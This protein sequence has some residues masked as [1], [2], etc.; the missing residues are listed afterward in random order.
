MEYCEKARVFR[1]MHDTTTIPWTRVVVRTLIVALPLVAV[2]LFIADVEA[3]LDTVARNVAP[4]LLVVVL[5]AVSLI[6]NGGRWWRPDARWPLAVLG[7]ALPAV[8]LSVYLHGL[9]HYDVDELRSAARDQRL[10]FAYL[11]L[12]TS[13]AGAIGAALGWIVG[14]QVNASSVDHGVAKSRS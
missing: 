5:A 3:E 12:Y 4:L 14:R 10:L 13:V 2:A 11:P 6:R 7:F 8:G 9:W 1:V